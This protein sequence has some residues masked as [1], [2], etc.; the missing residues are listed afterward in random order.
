MYVRK[1]IDFWKKLTGINFERLRK[2]LTNIKNNL[3][4][5]DYMYLT[6]DALIGINNII[7]DSNSISQVK[8]RC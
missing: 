2:A 1:N 4:D 6:F 8:Q 3:I 7:A 5:F